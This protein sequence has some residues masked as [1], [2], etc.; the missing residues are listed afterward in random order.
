DHLD[1]ERFEALSRIIGREL[2][3]GGTDMRRDRAEI[4]LRFNRDNAERRTPAA[5][6]RM[7]GRGD[8]RLGRHAAMV[9]AIAA[10]QAAFDQHHAHAESRRA[11]RGG[12]PGSAGADDAQVR[13]ESAGHG[14]PVFGRLASVSL[15]PR[16]RFTMPGS[17]ATMPSAAKA[18]RISGVTRSDGVISSPAAASMTLSR[19]RPSQA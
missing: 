2:L 1:T 8:Q 15:P 9:Q 11:R 16:S 4:D 3:D 10:H 19:P 14:P 18:M 7:P 6:M 12:Q 13:I 17:R 5:G